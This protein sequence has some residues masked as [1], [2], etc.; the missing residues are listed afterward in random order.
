M[1]KFFAAALAAVFALS[2]FPPARVFAAGSP[3]FS[4]SSGIAAER[5]ATVTVPIT[6]S[7]NPGFAACGLVVT[8]DPSVLELT[9]VTDQTAS[10][11]LSSFQLT[12]TQGSQWISLVND[13]RPLAD[14]RGNG[15]VA[16]MTF[17]VKQNAPA[18][19][20]A[21]SL[22][23]TNSPDGRPANAAGVVLRDAATSSGSVSVSGQG[24]AAAANPAP[25]VSQSADISG[26]VRQSEIDAAVAAAVNNFIGA[27]ASAAPAPAAAAEP[28]RRQTSSFGA[29]PQTRVID[30]PGTLAAIIAAGL[31]AAAALIYAFVRRRARKRSNG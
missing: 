12:E 9:R 3:G 25:G 7:D 14:W 17:T 27:A 10:M 2:A 28:V 6:V 31:A 23:F 22:A 15:T 13:D 19:T 8:Y 21:V 11:R 1:K 16:V 26:A 30:A 29:V 5:G 4:V 24:G 18:G 20:S